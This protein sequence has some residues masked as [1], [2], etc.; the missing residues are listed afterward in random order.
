MADSL[1]EVIWAVAGFKH[2]SWGY[3][4]AHRKYVQN[5]ILILLKVNNL[6]LN[7]YIL[8]I[9]ISSWFLQITRKLQPDM[10]VWRFSGVQS[11]DKLEAGSWDELHWENG[12]KNWLKNFWNLSFY[13]K[14]VKMSIFFNS[15][16][17][18]KFWETFFTN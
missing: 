17:K 3:T 8:Y 14:I 12:E 7:K 9:F 18:D 15:E 6:N 5:I 2:R 13:Q 11:G 4:Q 16:E 1:S 10:C